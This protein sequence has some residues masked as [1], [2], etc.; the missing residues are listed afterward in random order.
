MEREAAAL[1]GNF[2]ISLEQKLMNRDNK[3]A[4]CNEKL[5]QEV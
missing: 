2:S 4:G 5:D 3:S 1:T